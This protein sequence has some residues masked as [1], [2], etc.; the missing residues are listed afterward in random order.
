VA[1]VYAGLLARVIFIL[2]I[3][4]VYVDLFLSLFGAWDLGLWSNGD[5]FV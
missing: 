2:L 3:F 5:D 4:G 1:R